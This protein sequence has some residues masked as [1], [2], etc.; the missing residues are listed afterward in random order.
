[1]MKC[2]RAIL[3]LA[4]ICNPQQEDKFS[5]PD[6]SVFFTASVIWGVIGPKNQFSKGQTYYRTYNNDQINP[7]LTLPKAL[8]FFFILG[9]VLP[10]IVWYLMK[11]FPSSF[12]R[13]VKFVIYFTLLQT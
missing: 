4:D 1:M 13:Y 5:C 3:C 2:S 12:L 11:R 9:A 7:I 6:T 10:L 8:M